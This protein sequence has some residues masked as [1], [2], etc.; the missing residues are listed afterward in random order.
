VLRHEQAARLSRRLPASA[1]FMTLFSGTAA[2]AIAFTALLRWRGLPWADALFL[3]CAAAMCALGA[4]L[5]RHCRKFK[6]I[7]RESV[8]NIEPSKT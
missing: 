6:V 5:L 8:N 3:F 2:L 1:F 4:V 7:K